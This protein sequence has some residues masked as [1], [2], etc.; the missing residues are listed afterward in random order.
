MRLAAIVVHHRNWPDVS[1]T[2]RS[3]DEQTVAPDARI[4]VDVHSADGSADAIAEAHPAWEVVRLD[5]NS[6]YAAAVNA[7][8][9]L[10]AVRSADRMLVCTHEV[11]LDKGAV[12]AMLAAVD[13]DSTIGAAGPILS[14]RSDG[15]LWSAGGGL[16]RR[17]ARP[18]HRQHAPGRQS[19]PQQVEWVDG[20]VVLYRAEAL[21]RTGPLDEAYFLYYE[22]LDYQ[23]RLRQAGWRVV[24]VPDATAS[25]EPGMVPPYLEA[26]NRVR[27]LR[28]AHRWV[29]LLFAIVEQLFTALAVLTSRDR[30][31]ESTLRLKGL[32]H[33][34]TGRL[35]Q[36]VA[37]RRS[38]ASRSSV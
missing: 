29:P 25:Q 19:P 1:D 5:R 10:Q 38:A 7:A 18:W 21:Q 12:E 36:T 31:W 22:E 11:L 9:E 33:G 26:R 2:L 28:R 16:G 32:V 17:T 23:C 6:G 34:F 3:I 13:S 14:R 27:W 8:L 37:L 24:A 4:V 15:S 30:R 20:A 35:D